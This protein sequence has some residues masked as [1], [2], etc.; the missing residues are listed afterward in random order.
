M[1]F[2]YSYAAHMQSNVQDPRAHFERI[3][4]RCKETMDAQLTRLCLRAQW[5]LAN[6]DFENL[7]YNEVL[8]DVQAGITTLRKLR[9]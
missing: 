1:Y 6:S 8:E 9:S 3:I 7:C 5:E 4:A 2:S